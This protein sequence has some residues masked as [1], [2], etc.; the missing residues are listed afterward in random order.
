METFLQLLA[1]NTLTRLVFFPTL[2]C[3]PLLFIKQDS[4]A[5][6]YALVI[7]FI[8]AGLGLWLVAANALQVG[9]AVAV[10]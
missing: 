2:A 1:G 8:E 7:G 4:A 5:R 3:L 6:A 10:E 9:A